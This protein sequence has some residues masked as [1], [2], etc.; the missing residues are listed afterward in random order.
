M[1]TDLNMLEKQLKVLSK[2]ATSDQWSELA[3]ATKADAEDLDS[4]PEK[5]KM[6]AL[7]DLAY[8]V[9]EYAAQ[10]EA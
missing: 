8:A 1:G 10:C 5:H 6:S 2:Q 9:C 3:D 7:A 4:G